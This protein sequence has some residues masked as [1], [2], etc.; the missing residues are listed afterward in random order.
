MLRRFV[1]NTAISAVAYAAAGVLGLFAVGVIA[2]SY[3]VAVLG[4]IVLVRSFL[5]TGLL[6]LVD[7]GV[8]ETTTQAIAR[9]RAGDLAIAS[10]KTSLLGV[11]AVA[12]GV[13]SAVVLWIIASPLTM[14]FKVASDHADAFTSIL[15]V[16]AL[17]LPVAFLGLFVEGVLKG[18]EQ[19]GWLRFTEVSGNAL[20]VVAVYVLAWEGAPFE[21][22]AYAYLAMMV[23]KYF[24]LAVVVWRAAQNSSLRLCSWTAESRQ[25]VFRRSWLMFNNRMLGIWQQ[26]VIPFAIGVL[27]SPAEVGAYD[28]ITRLP[29]FLKATMAPLYSAILPMSAH[30]EQA[31]DIRRLQILGRN[32][33]VL[34]SAIVVPVLVV[35]ALFS[36]QILRVWVGPQ[37]SDQWPWLA[38]S[39]FIPATSA[40]LGAGQTALMVRSEFLRFSTRLLTLQV[41][42]QYLVTALALAWLQERAFIL[43]WVVSFIVFAPVSAHY[44]LSHMNL[45][46]SLFWKQLGKHVLVASLL[47]V[48]VAAGKMIFTPDDLTSLMIVGGLACILAW[49]L[50]G[51]IILSASDRAMLGRFAQAMFKRSRT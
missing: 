9:G 29:R 44:V 12:T 23:A 47:A 32:G 20:Y 33:F 40:M 22:I 41:V 45:P 35:A 1:Q 37:Y 43:G 25:D 10:E 8:S 39:M 31:S 51:A 5:P 38:L 4:L 28:L 14:I 2:R 42:T 48:V 17:V 6:A 27:Y 11:I 13:I 3:G 46:S 36:E 30:I 34:P 26:P 18:F 15:R 19:Y 7:F 21:G 16:T 24:V 50:S 49:I